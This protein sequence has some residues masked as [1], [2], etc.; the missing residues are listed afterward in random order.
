MEIKFQTKKE[1]KQEQRE[2]FLKL[3]P[4]ERF[5]NFLD[6]CEYMLKFPLK[7]TAK[8]SQENFVIEASSHGKNLETKHR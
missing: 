3:E 4:N 6:L 2:A 7:T 5:Y 8:T 1:S